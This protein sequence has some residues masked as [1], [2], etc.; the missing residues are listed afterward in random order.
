[1]NMA[2]SRV[3]A[4]YATDAI[5]ALLAGQ[6]V[7]V[8]HS[9]SLGC[10]TKWITNAPKVQAELAKVQSKPVKFDMARREDI[11]KLRAN[12][13][14]LPVHFLMLQCTDCRVVLAINFWSLKCKE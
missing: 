13:T 9:R 12:S 6:P 8:E 2:P 5:D 1:D 4:H 3:K 7:P 14:G 11:K 10:S